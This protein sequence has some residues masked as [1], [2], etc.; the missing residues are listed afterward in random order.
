MMDTL[1]TVLI[2]LSYFN[3]WLEVKQLSDISAIAINGCVA[4]ILCVN[5]KVIGVLTVSLFC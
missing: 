4:V 5:R 1:V 2:L 3:E